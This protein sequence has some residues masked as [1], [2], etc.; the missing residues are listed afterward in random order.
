[1]IGPA[2]VQAI[3]SYAAG[4]SALYPCQASKLFDL[5]LA[6]LDSKKREK[7]AALSVI[8]LLAPCTSTSTSH[9]ATG[10]FGSVPIDRV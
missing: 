9:Q 10:A 6:E 4:K 7:Y 2:L 5:W 1:M 8:L 3:Q